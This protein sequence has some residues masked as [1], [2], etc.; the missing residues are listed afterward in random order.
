MVNVF[1]LVPLMMV[2]TA[3]AAVE[4]LVELV[5]LVEPLQPVMTGI[6]IV[7]N[8]SAASNP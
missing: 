2:R 8:N 3:D 5:E 7:I 6:I 4:E 1:V